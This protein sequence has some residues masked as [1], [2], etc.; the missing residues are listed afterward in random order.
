MTE[1]YDFPNYAERRQQVRQRADA[2]GVM[3]GALLPERLFVECGFSEDEIDELFDDDNDNYHVQHRDDNT[4]LPLAQVLT[5]LQATGAGKLDNI[6]HLNRLQ[7][8]GDDEQ[9]WTRELE[10]LIYNTVYTRR[11]GFG[12]PQSR[13]D[14]FASDRQ[15]DHDNVPYQFLSSV[16]DALDLFDEPPDNISSDPLKV[17]IQAL[18]TIGRG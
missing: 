2:E 15:Y 18:L 17:C 4:A 10:R 1:M 11:Q 3:Y 12:N 16:D 13:A 14:W 5:L 6:D 9:N 8:V 7:V